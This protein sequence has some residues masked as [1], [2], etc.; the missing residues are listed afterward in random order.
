MSY[1]CSCRELNPGRPARSLVTI[2]TDLLWIIRHATV[3]TNLE[4]SGYMH[5]SSGRNGIYFSDPK[6]NTNAFEMPVLLNLKFSVLSKKVFF[7]Y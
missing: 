1:H 6:K 3:I 2:L 4:R 5:A 7:L